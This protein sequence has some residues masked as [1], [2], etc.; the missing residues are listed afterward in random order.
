MIRLETLYHADK[1]KT[2]AYILDLL[3][4]LHQLVNKARFGVISGGMKSAIKYPV[5]TSIQ[6][7]NKHTKPEP[8]M[9]PPLT[10]EEQELLQKVAKRNRVPGISNSL[11]FDKIRL[12][13][14]D[15]LSKSS[16]QSPQRGSKELA[17]TKRLPSHVPIIGFGIEKEKALDV[18]DR[19]DVLR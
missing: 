9:F 3:L 1:E 13:R 12:K 5:G 19:V 14:Y 2:E 18:I 17:A 8:S 11:D 6:K 7:T 16:G 15:R 10:S 4:W